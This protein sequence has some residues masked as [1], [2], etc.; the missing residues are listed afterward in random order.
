VPVTQQS[1]KLID[2]ER[3]KASNLS[4]AGGFRYTAPYVLRPGNPVVELDS[5]LLDAARGRTLT[6]TVEGKPVRHGRL[7]LTREPA[8][9]H[10]AVYRV[11][12]AGAGVPPDHFTLVAIPSST[13]RRFQAWLQAEQKDVGWI[14]ALPPVYASLGPGGSNP[15]PEGCNPRF[16]PVL[17]SVD[18]RY[19]P[20]AAYEMRSAIR[21]DG[22]GH[23]ATY[24]AKGDLI[25]HGPGA[26]SADRA[27]PRRFN[28]LRLIAHRD[29]DVIPFV[30]AAQLDGNPVN[31]AAFY[32]DF[33]APLLREGEHMKAY[34]RVRPA[35]GPFGREIPPG[36]CIDG[37]VP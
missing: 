29:R 3:V 27:S 16:W 23:Q 15:E 2:A 4:A 33:D 37:R 7:V 1:F 14:R 18:V 21:E 22:S 36:V 8:E 25:R 24:D 10:T 12:V 11:A 20:G 30:W 34:M 19:H 13:P 31:P 5:F 17:R 6:W 26:G 32:A 9:N 28:P 35:F